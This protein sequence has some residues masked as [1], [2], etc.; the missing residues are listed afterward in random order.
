MKKSLLSVL[1]LGT[2]TVGLIAGCSKDTNKKTSKDP[3]QT[4]WTETQKARMSEYLYGE[5]LPFVDAGVN[6][7]VTYDAESENIIVK[8]KSKVSWN[9]LDT[10]AGKYT[11]N[12]GWYVMPTSYEEV[13]CFEKECSIEGVNRYLNVQTTLVDKDGYI[14]ETSKGY[15]YIIAGDPYVY[16]WP[17]TDVVEMAAEFSSDISIPEIEA[18]HYISDVDYYNVQAYYPYAGEGIDGGYS[19]ILSGNYFYV[20]S[21]LDSDGYHIANSPDNKYSV[22]YKYFADYGMLDI[23]L[24]APVFDTL[25]TELINNAFAKYASYGAV[26]FEFPSPTGASIN[27]SFAEDDWNSLYAAFGSYSSINGVVTVSGL[28][29]EEYNDYRTL[30]TNQSWTLEVDSYGNYKATKTQNDYINNI[31]LSYKSNVLTITVYLISEHAPYL[32]WPT[33]AVAGFFPGY[34]TD[35]VPA[36]TGSFLNFVVGDMS[37]VVNLDSSESLTPAQALEAYASTLTTNSF[38]PVLNDNEVVI[39]YNSPNA[40]FQI[41]LSATETGL[42][43]TVSLL[44]YVNDSPNYIINAW[45][46]EFEYTTNIFPSITYTDAR[47]EVTKYSSGGVTVK[48]SG[49]SEANQQALQDYVAGLDASFNTSAPTH[50]WGTN[51]NEYTST[52][53]G[54]SVNPYISGDYFIIRIYPASNN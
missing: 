44:P 47:W 24:D 4:D 19:A 10:Y 28:S 22:R 25:P 26:A 30:L 52:T 3:V 15:L 41:N 38:I 31:V 5:I 17:G 36:Y 6:L 48:T 54:L 45:L 29:V 11:E 35:V 27:F 18:S 13:Y 23:Y 49:S 46:E 7:S 16:S 14:S 32:S 42:K 20:R 2:L 34:I 21:D 8:S 1:T 43:I 37:V 33:D 12:D 51:D 9:N 53:Y 39:G 50:T 40:Q